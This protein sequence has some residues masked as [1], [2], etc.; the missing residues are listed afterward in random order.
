[1]NEQEVGVLLDELLEEIFVC[2]MYLM[3][4]K[5]INIDL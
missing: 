3:K 5:H 4:I 1:M 2:E